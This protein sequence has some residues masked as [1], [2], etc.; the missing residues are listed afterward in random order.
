MKEIYEPKFVEKL[1]DK[2]SRSYSKVNYVTS[3]GF[4]ERWRRQCVEEIEIQK[5]KVIVDL[6]TGMGE[7]WKHILAKC[8]K[9]SKLISLDFSTKMINRAKNNKEKLNIYDI[10]ILKENVF[11][12][13]IKDQTADYVISGFGMKTFNDNQLEKLAIEIHRI[14]K[15]NGK[16]SL[17]DV[18]VPKNS[19]LKP[20]YL[21]YL[22]NVIPILGKIFLGSPETYKMLGVYTQE[23]VNSKNVEQIFRKFNFEVEYVDYFYGCATGI[24]GRKIK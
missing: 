10:E 7:C 13:S 12:N 1:F 2:M 23:F 8:N 21:F 11:E 5:G 24:K 9:D 15:P 20:F 17:V 19:I 14:L 16:F 3:F 6:M 18:S 4:S 22:K